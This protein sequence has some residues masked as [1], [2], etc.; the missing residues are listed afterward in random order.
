MVIVSALQPAVIEVMYPHGVPAGAWACALLTPASETNT[1]TI[2][3]ANSLNS[4]LRMALPP[5][6]VVIEQ[7]TCAPTTSDTAPWKTTRPLT[8][9][10]T[11][12]RWHLRLRS[13]PKGANH[14]RVE[15]MEE[16]RSCTDIVR[17]IGHTGLPCCPSCKSINQTHSALHL[18]NSR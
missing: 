4:L 7:F 3:P 1:M 11:I 2:A 8:S 6:L 15:C 13:W 14:S 10:G 17:A 12:A 18:Y 5:R 16:G 9:A